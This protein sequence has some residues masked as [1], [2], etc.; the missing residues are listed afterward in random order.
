MIMNERD[1]TDT[2]RFKEQCEQLMKAGIS[3]KDLL[4]YKELHKQFDIW[5]N[6]KGTDYSKAVIAYDTSK[7]G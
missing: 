6:E 1:Y 4:R 3:E 5:G 7:L 2:V